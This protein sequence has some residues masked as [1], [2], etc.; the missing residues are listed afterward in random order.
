MTPRAVKAKP[1]HLWHPGTLSAWIV[2]VPSHDGNMWLRIA[3]ESIAANR[4]F[5]SNISLLGKRIA[6]R[7]MLLAQIAECEIGRLRIIRYRKSSEAGE[8]EVA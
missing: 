3:P 5:P 7:D 1:F 2:Y 4:N 6:A 8:R